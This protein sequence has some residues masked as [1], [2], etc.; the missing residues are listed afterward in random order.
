[1]SWPELRASYCFNLLMLLAD[2]FILGYRGARKKRAQ[3]TGPG[4]HQ[5]SGPR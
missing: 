2:L 4:S 5:V 1:M 3:P